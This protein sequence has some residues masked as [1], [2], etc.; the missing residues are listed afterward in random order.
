VPRR[1]TKPTL[2]LLEIFVGDPQR[3]WYG[4]ELMDLAGL[5]SGTVYPIL[6]RLAADGWLSAHQEDIDPAVERRPARRLYAITG[7]GQVNAERELDRRV[8]S[9]RSA[10]LLSPRVGEARA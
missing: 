1:I 7:V 9:P 4:L 8:R 5:K 6:H 2:R 10:P 3:S